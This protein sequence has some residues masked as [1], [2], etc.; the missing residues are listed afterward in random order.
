MGPINPAA[1]YVGDTLF[2]KPAPMILEKTRLI[3]EAGSG[4][5]SRCTPTEMWPTPTAFLYRSGLVDS[6]NAGLSS[7]LCGGA[8]RW[9]TRARWPTASCAPPRRS[10]T[11]IPRRRSCVRRRPRVDVPGHDGC[12][13]RPGRDV[14]HDLALA[15]SR[16][17]HPVK[18]RVARDGKAAGPGA[19]ARGRHTA[20]LPRDH[21]RAA[22]R[23]G[24]VR[25]RRWPFSTDAGLLLGPPP[26]EGPRV[27]EH[28]TSY[29]NVDC[30][31]SSRDLTLHTQVT[32]SRTPPPKQGRTQRDRSAPCATTPG[33]RPSAPA[34][35]LGDSQQDL[36]CRAS[37]KRQ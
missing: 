5:T 30:P 34:Q 27:N 6:D 1:T 19:W 14:G 16:R 13:A 29:R 32:L 33:P 2:A 25:L 28:S 9:P 20:V 22:T 8:A 35:A 3:L 18:P 4:C 10:T 36:R 7:R 12:D 17:P 37:G 23:R 26:T 31:G 15:A 21:G 24:G 11:R